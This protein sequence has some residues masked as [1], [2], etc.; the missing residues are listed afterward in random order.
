VAVLVA[1]HD[2]RGDGTP[3]DHHGEDDPHERHGSVCDHRHISSLA[4]EP[5]RPNNGRSRR[6]SS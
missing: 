1:Q 4:Q 2:V 3:G 6:G 5:Y